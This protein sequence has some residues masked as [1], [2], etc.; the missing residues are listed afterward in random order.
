MVGSDVPGRI[1][2]RREG[3]AA[4]LA[5]EVAPPRTVGLLPVPTT[6]A[7]LAGVAG[8]YRGHGHT[9]QRRLVARE[10]E[11]AREGPRVPAPTL[12]FAPLQA[13]AD[14]GQVLAAQVCAGL[15]GLDQALGQ[16]VVAVPA[17]TF[18]AAEHRAP[19]PLGRPWAFRLK[20][21]APAERTGL[22][23]PPRA[24][25]E[26]MGLESYG[27]A[28][29]AEL[30][31]DHRSC[32]AHVRLR[33]LDHDVQPKRT[34][35]VHAELGRTSRE[36]DARGRAEWDAQRY[37]LPISN[38]RPEGTAFGKLDL[39]RA[40]VV[41]AGGARRMWAGHLPALAPA[42]TAGRNGFSGSYTAGADQLRRRRCSRTFICVGLVVEFHSVEARH[43][44]THRADVV[45]HRGVLRAALTP[46]RHARRQ[47]L[48]APPKSQVQDHILPA[49]AGSHK[50]ENA[51][52]GPRLIPGLS[53]GRAET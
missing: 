31:T 15:H 30:N 39:G 1:Q 18:L 45:E 38:T 24:L 47:R 25:A 46:Y 4:L 17:E 44:P 7:L 13:C 34:P 21:T 35:A 32:G 52:P 11:Q 6:A 29:N 40:S 26:E 5:A 48:H 36:I 51:R 8:V 16:H 43:L 3:A 23:F 20:S 49:L 37:P 50:G 28:H 14:V 27:G 33:G 19:V 10:A 22:D 53:D 42:G 41:A 12:P 2:V 9:R